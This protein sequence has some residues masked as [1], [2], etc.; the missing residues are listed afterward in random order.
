M[1]NTK[2]KSK[3]YLDTSVISYLEQDDA[4]EKM[5]ITRNVWE[6]LKR[7][8]YDI[9]LSNTVIFELNKCKDPKK[10]DLLMSHLEEIQ[11]YLV[12]IVDDAE[13]LA[14]YL[15]ERG[16]LKEKNLD[17]CK[18]IATAMVY[19][20]DCII[21]WNFKHIVKYKTMN[22]IR[23]IALEQGRKNILIYSPESFEEEL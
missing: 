8:D 14:H 23:E 12:D 16:I 2:P 13:G 10:R 21:S 1:E 20:C 22:V 19:E 11:Y 5:R 15:I 18:H 3:L 17:D 9:Y 6:Q 7:G 4:P